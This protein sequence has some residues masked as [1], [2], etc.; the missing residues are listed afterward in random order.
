MK[1]TTTAERH[2]EITRSVAL[3]NLLRN[4]M[5]ETS[6]YG[7]AGKYDS[8]MNGASNTQESKKWQPIF[9]GKRPLTPGLLATLTG[10]FPD[11]PTIYRNGPD[12]LWKSM[13]GDIGELIAC[14]R[15]TAPLQMPLAFAENAVE[16]RILCS[17][18]SGLA[19]LSHAIALYRFRS[20][21]APY[22]RTDGVGL[23]LAG[24]AWR[25]V[26]MCLNEAPVLRELDALGV[27]SRILDEIID[28]E[29]MRVKSNPR[30][31]V[32]D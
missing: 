20:G 10:L 1:S 32:F 22:A 11:V 13:W 27:R 25:C 28:A 18:P 30:A 15:S 14:V 8:Q 4:R 19:D 7:F 23:N 29:R 17:G 16:G 31:A 6:V 12:D 3:L 2:R 24:R 9:N 21:T 26:E 5:G